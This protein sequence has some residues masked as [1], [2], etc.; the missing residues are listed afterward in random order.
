MSEIAWAGAGVDVGTYAG[1]VVAEGRR[2]R[3]QI[4]NVL[5]SEFVTL[6]DEQAAALVEAM[7]VIASALWP[8][9]GDLVDE[10]SYLRG[11]NACAEQ[12]SA[13]LGLD[14]R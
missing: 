7:P 2:R 11:W 5:T 6:S 1:P 14:P 8:D 12:L 4:T 13:R 3:V 9:D 10:A